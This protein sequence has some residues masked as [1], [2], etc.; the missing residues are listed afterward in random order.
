ME[1]VLLQVPLAAKG[2]EQHFSFLTF[3]LWNSFLAEVLQ[4]LSIVMSQIIAIKIRLLEIVES[5]ILDTA[6]LF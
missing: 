5:F 6:L 4:S 2:K 1:E 3:Q